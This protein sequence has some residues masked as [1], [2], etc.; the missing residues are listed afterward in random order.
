MSDRYA[1]SS[2]IIPEIMYIKLMVDEPPETDTFD[3]LNAIRNALKKH[4]KTYL[5]P[6]LDNSIHVLSTFLDPRYKTMFFTDVP[7]DSKQHITSI[8]RELIK[9]YENIHDYD[10][11][12]C[13]TSAI[14][15]VPVQPE[16]GNHEKGDFREW[17]YNKFA[18]KLKAK[19]YIL[20]SSESELTIRQKI[21]HEVDRYCNE[22]MI[23][24]DKSP[25]DWWRLNKVIYP[26]LAGLSI[27]YLSSPPSTVESERLF[28][29][30]GNIYSPHRNRLDPYTG[31]KLI[32]LNYNLGLLGYK[33]SLKFSY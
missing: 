13:Q 30:A 8:K 7:I 33:Y 11:I 28:S 4:I 26:T 22:G 25:V 6:Y 17:A 15:V 29:I 2:S 19:G 24:E 18:S 3:G 20:P 16:V 12:A 23:P 32:F 1:N 31:E 14:N 27:K 10:T 9:Q 21:E 5:D